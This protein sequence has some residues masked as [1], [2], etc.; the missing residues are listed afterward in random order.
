YSW[1]FENG[2]TSNLENPVV[3]FNL[4]G[5][6]NAQL[7][8]VSD[9]GCA[10]TLSVA[11]A[12]VVL[13]KPTANFTYVRLPDKAFDVSTLRFTN[14]SS[15]DVTNFDWDFGNGN[16]SNE[17]NPENDYTDTSRRII[18]LVVT[19]QDGCMDTV[20]KESGSLVTDF[21]FYLPTAFSPNNQDGNELFVPVATPYVRYYR[22]EIYNRWGEKVFVTDDIK[23]GWDGKYMGQ[24]CEQ[25]VYI[26]RVYLV[27]MRGAIQSHEVT[28][29]LLR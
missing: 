19:N 17:E 2:Q 11:G 26:C 25:G 18:T 8:T 16:Y 5:S 22:L 23:Q 15:N 6:Y 27:P 20:S 7:I 1:T 29:T 12:A 24:D 3:D 21:K 13:P 28:V 9:Q 14:Q 10:D 4:P